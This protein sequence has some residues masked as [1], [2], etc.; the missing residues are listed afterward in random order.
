MRKV[1][2]VMSVAPCASCCEGGCDAR[3]VRRHALSLIYLSMSTSSSNHSSRCLP[4]PL[5]RSLDPRAL[6]HVLSIS[7]RLRAL[8]LWSSPCACL[9]RPNLVLFLTLVLVPVLGLLSRA[10]LSAGAVR[11]FAS[12]VRQRDA[13]SWRTARGYWIVP[14]SERIHVVCKQ[15][16]DL[17]IDWFLV[18]SRLVED[19]ERTAISDRPLH[20]RP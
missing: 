14:R 19:G 16:P 5:A 20:G 18:G 11:T 10:T 1:P 9:P 2:D 3:N 8:L 15:Y 7:T 4:R 13:T 17:V 6:F 12:R